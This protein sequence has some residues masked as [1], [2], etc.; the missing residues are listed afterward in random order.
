MTLREATIERLKT[1]S[2]LL[3]E[4]KFVLAINGDGHDGAQEPQIHFDSGDIG[5]TAYIEGRFSDGCRFSTGQP[6]RADH[7]LMEALR[8]VLRRGLRVD[9]EI[10]SEN[11]CEVYVGERDEF[12]RTSKYAA[13]DNPLHAILDAVREA[14]L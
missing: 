14:G 11:L 8:A 9:M 4:W 12:A 1:L 10:F 6:G 13:A 3:P 2:G 7:L 5:E